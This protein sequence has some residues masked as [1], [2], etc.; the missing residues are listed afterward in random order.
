MHGDGAVAGWLAAC[1]PAFLPMVW[2]MG[3]TTRPGARVKSVFKVLRRRE[4]E[5][6]FGMQL[7]ESVCVCHQIRRRGE[8]WI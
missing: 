5:G 8:G 6:S 4:K 7:K 1:L 2:E 3:T